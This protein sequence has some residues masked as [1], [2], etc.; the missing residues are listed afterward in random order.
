MITAKEARLISHKKELL[1]RVAEIDRRLDSF[2]YARKLLG[3]GNNDDLNKTE[4]KILESAYRG[5]YKSAIRTDELADEKTIV[6]ALE[7]CGYDTEIRHDCS[8]A[9]GIAWQIKT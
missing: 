3:I 7:L 2:G 6:V 9:I 5:W 4:E 8:H 1:D